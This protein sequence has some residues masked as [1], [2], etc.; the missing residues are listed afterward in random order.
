LKNL[1]PTSV[2]VAAKDPLLQRLDALLLVTK[3]CTGSTCRF[4]WRELHQSGK[5][6]RLAD[7]LDK[8]FDGFYAQLSKTTRVRFDECALGYIRNVEGPQFVG[9]EIE[10]SYWEL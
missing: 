8:K 9:L 1:Y 3:S 5:V 4:P 7:A 2:S 6:K 10:D